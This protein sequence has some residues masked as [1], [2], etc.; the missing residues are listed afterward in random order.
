MTTTDILTKVIKDTTER[1]EAQSL[2]LISGMSI[3]QTIPFL[4]RLQAIRD[5][6]AVYAREKACKACIKKAQKNKN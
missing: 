4:E 2:S 6:E 3:N 1:I 5:R